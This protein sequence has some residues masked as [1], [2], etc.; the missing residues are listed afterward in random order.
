MSH[1]TWFVISELDEDDIIEWEFNK[2]LD[3]NIRVHNELIEQNFC[4][5]W[6]F[7]WWYADYVN[8]WWLY[9]WHL[10]DIL[11]WFKLSEYN[12]NRFD[13]YWLI[14][15]SEI[16]ETEEQFNN[17]KQYCLDQ[18]LYIFNLADWDIYN[19]ESDW[20]IEAIE[21]HFTYNNNKWKVVT[22]IDFHQ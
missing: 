1:Y 14:D 8:I 16:I 21:K 20:N 19:F 4:S 13:T 12:R 15:D 7:G 22:I 18:W 3:V 17:L 11:N 5:Q 9:S 10:N 2:E 6:M